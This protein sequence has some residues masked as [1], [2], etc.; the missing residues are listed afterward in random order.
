MRWTRTWLPEGA[1][2]RALRIRQLI[3]D[4][5]AFV[6]L[7]AVRFWE[8]RCTQSASALAYTS[9]LALVPLMT[10]MV[11]IL[12]AFPAFSDVR[13]RAQALVF[14]TLVPQV[15]EALLENLESFADRAGSLTGVGVVGLIVTSVML[16]STIEGAFNSIWRVRDERSLIVRI[17]SF[18]AIL[19]MTPILVAASISVTTQF[20]AT[21]EIDAADPLWGWVLGK[22]PVLFQFLGFSLLYRLIPNCPV[23]TSDAMVGGLVTAVLFEVAKTGFT[24]YV[25]YFPTYQTVYGALATVPIFLVW[26]YLAWSIILLGAVVAAT[27]PDWRT[28]KLLGHHRSRRLHPSQRLM[29]ALAVMREIAVAGREGALPVRKVLLQRLPVSGPML[30]ETL[31]ALRRHRFA[32]STADDGWVVA[33]D[34]HE[35]TVL[36]LA[37]VL[38]LA[39]ADPDLARVEPFVRLDGAWLDQVERILKAIRD[40]EQHRLGQPLAGLVAGRADGLGTAPDPIPLDSEARRG[41][42]RL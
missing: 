18:W 9:L 42:A 22:L 4:L 17:L 38:D 40:D 12:S 7:A 15:G 35:T 10:V 20:F 29:L 6:R 23:R 37:K 33:R 31:E 1:V 34:L 3:G 41:A 39:I 21:A 26:L 28:G 27:V 13:Y 11:G 30:D 36:D 8:D 24:L 16:L 2:T 14:N 19:T 25:T 32:V 5:V